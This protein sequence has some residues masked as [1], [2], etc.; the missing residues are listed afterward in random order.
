MIK[1]LYTLRKDHYIIISQ[2]QTSISMSKMNLLV[3]LSSNREKS[4]GKQLSRAI[5]A[6]ETFYLHRRQQYLSVYH[7]IKHEYY[8][9]IEL[10]SITI[11]YWKYQ[12]ITLC[13]LYKKFSSASWIF[14]FNSAFYFS[15]TLF[16]NIEETNVYNTLNNLIIRIM[17]KFARY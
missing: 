4:A 14:S 12:I 7:R 9:Y 15:N 17:K 6:S 3:K 1:F 13:Y 16:L 5:G 8:C 2:Y 10:Y 11:F